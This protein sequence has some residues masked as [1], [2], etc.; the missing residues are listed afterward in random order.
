MIE[1]ILYLVLIIIMVLI[2]Y[3]N[4]K[5]KFRLTLL[6]NGNLNTFFIL[7]FLLFTILENYIIGV[8]LL[9]LYFIIDIEKNNNK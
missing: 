2:P 9:L 8:L 5:N 6:T 7:L 1:K 3:F 4:K